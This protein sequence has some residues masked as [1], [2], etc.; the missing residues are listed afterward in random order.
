MR[1][2]QQSD[3]KQS[4]KGPGL[5]D[6]RP[7]ISPWI[8]VV[9]LAGLL[10]ANMYFLSQA[11]PNEIEYG[12]FLDAVRDGYV[13]ELLAPLPRHAGIVTVIDGHPT[14]LGWLGGVWGHQVQPLGV[15]HF[16]QSGSVQELYSHHGIDT[17][18][19]VDAAQDALLSRPIRY[20]AG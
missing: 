6:K 16:G 9:I 1:Q 8:Y 12:R 15:E 20:A 3:D 18:A 11:D 13:E 14:T 2:D 5:M 4:P 19:I 10:V 7:R 17:Q